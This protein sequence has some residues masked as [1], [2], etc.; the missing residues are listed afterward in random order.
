MSY[1]FAWAVEPV[2]WFKFRLHSL[3]S[4]RVLDK[5]LNLSASQF[6]SSIK[7]G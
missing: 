6:S 5:L 3:L 1:S 7:L 4:V 2:P